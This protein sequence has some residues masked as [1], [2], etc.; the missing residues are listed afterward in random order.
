M[1]VIEYVLQDSMGH[2]NVGKIA[3]HRLHVRGSV[4]CKTFE[5][6]TI[7]KRLIKLTQAVE[8]KLRKKKEK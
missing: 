7:T 2:V 1:H 8:R 4:T 6:K 3:I 5:D